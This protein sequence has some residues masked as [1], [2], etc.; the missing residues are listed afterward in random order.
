MKR[1]AMIL[2]FIICMSGCAAPAWERVEDQVPPVPVSAKEEPYMV[3]VDVPQGMELVDQNAYSSLYSTQLGDF[4]VQTDCFY[5][6][7]MADAVKMITG[8]EAETMTV[9]QTQ[10]FGLPEYQFVWVTNTEQGSRVCRGD[11]VMDGVNCYCVVCSAAEE[12]AGSF[13]EDVRYVFSTFGL[14]LDEGV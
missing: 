3:L 9:L 4:E 13:F 5:A 14:S 7:D 10:R 6:S 11:L 8:M 1:L 12:Q 2:A